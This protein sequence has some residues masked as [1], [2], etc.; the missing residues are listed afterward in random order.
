MR[1]VRFQDGTGRTLFGIDRGDGSAH[2]LG[3]DPLSE[4]VH[5]TGQVLP[6]ARRLA[7]VEP[8]NIYCIGQNYRKHIEE[9]GH[10]PPPRPV[11]FMK[12]TT[13]LTHPG[14][15]IRLPA[16]QLDGPETDYECELAVVIGKAAHNVPVDQALDCVLGYSAANDVSARHWQMTGGGGQWVRGKGFDTFCPLG[17]VLV[18]ADEIPNPQH[19]RLSTTLNGNVVQD[20]NTSDML[21]GVAELIA[22]LSQ[23]TTLLPGTL[24]LTGTPPGVGFARDP[25][26]L[27]KPGDEVVV[28]VEKIGRLHNPVEAA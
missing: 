26:L 1:I 14:D 7:P 24:I 2:C 5:E 18:T 6:I 23:D 22:F 10:Q 16:C 8:I 19:L 3:G 27:L 11:V 17:P 21:F 12:P 4:P 25:K 15:P 9:M 13:A 20:S 28:E